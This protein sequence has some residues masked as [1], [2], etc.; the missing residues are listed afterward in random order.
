MAYLQSQDLDDSRLEHFEAEAKEAP[1][2]RYNIAPFQPVRLCAGITAAS[3]RDGALRTFTVLGEGF[4]HEALRGHAHRHPLAAVHGF[5]H[6][7]RPK[8]AHEVRRACRLAGGGQAKPKPPLCKK[9]WEEPY[10]CDGEEDC[11]LA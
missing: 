8:T 3:L 10:A 7:A 9:F 6:R 1:Q 5:N 11:V 2:P 4:C